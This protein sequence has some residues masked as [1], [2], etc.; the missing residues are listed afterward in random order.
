M[1]ALVRN[2]YAFEQPLTADEAMSLMMLIG[3]C[4][5]SRVLTNETGAVIG[6]VAHPDDV[7]SF[8]KERRVTDSRKRR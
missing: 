4:R 6:A 3:W 2:R 5:G 8:E 7:A 1:M